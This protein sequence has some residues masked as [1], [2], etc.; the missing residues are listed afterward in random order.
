MVAIIQILGYVQ[1]SHE[2][3]QHFQT[4]PP[5]VY[6]LESMWIVVLIPTFIDVTAVM[7]T[8]VPQMFLAAMM[9]CF[10]AQHM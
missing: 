8:A 4:V 10:A 9:Q 5:I 1:A 2:P 3:P 6:W 7:E